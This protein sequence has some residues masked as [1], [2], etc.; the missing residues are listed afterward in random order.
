MASQ[1]KGK[2]KGKAKASPKKGSFASRVATASP[3]KRKVEDE[4]PDSQPPEWEQED[5]EKALSEYSNDGAGE[6]ASETKIRKKFNYLRSPNS[7][8]PVPP[9]LVTEWTRLCATLPKGKKHPKKA[10]FMAEARI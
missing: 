8:T 4:L 1:A 10:E 7:R 3:K 5:F 9:D 2:G 6:D